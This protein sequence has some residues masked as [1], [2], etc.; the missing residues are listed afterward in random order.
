MLPSSPQSLLRTSVQSVFSMVHFS[1]TLS[2]AVCTTP[3]QQCN[4]GA[5]RSALHQ[6]FSAR[7][8]SGQNG[9]PVRSILAI[10][11]KSAFQANCTIPQS[12]CSRNQ[13]GHFNFIFISH[14]CSSPGRTSAARRS[15]V[16]RSSPASTLKR[17]LTVRLCSSHS[18]SCSGSRPSMELRIPAGVHRR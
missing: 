3:S 8:P 12:V 15:L 17:P 6:C 9:R 10:V 1:L 18:A 7:V 2:R 13:S 11:L 5:F 14:S 4:L 16:F